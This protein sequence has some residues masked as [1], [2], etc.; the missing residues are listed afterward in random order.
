MRLV[1]ILL[2]FEVCTKFKFLDENT[3][4]FIYLGLTLGLV[5]A[6]AQNLKDLAKDWK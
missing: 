1:I 4:T 2:L 5:V 6:I 3:G